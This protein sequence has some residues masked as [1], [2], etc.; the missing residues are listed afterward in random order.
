ML[1]D[2]NIALQNIGKSIPLR[3]QR[4]DEENDECQ[5]KSIA[6]AFIFGNSNNQTMEEAWSDDE[7]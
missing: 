4:I 2:I 5:G 3:P 6:S 7:H 1:E